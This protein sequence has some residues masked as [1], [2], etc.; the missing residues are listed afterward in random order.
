[1]IQVFFSHSSSNE[2][3]IS[4]LEARMRQLR[5]HIAILRSDVQAELDANANN[6]GV[7]RIRQ[8]WQLTLDYGIDL[9]ENEL[10]WLEKTIDQIRALQPLMPA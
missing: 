9:Y 3:I 4:L 1:L 10:H 5:Q 6:I 8:L 7:E 2:E